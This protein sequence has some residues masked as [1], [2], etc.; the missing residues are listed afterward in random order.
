MGWGSSSAGQVRA[1]YGWGCVIAP[2]QKS[3]RFLGQ[4]KQ[5]FFGLARCLPAVV[6]AR[7]R[8]QRCAALHLQVPGQ[9]L[10]MPCC[11]CLGGTLV[12]TRLQLDTETRRST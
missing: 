9:S 8:V 11:Q 12:K 2:A 7:I 4:T 10:W 5:W 6:A 3:R 1:G